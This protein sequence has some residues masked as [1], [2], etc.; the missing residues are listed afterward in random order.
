MLFC[1]PAYPDVLPSAG[2][3]L[4]HRPPS[5]CQN[6]VV[7]LILFWHPRM[8]LDSTSQ[9]QSRLVYRLLSWNR[10]QI[11]IRCAQ[12]WMRAQY[13]VIFPLPVSKMK[14]CAWWWIKEGSIT[15]SAPRPVWESRGLFDDD[16]LMIVMTEVSSW[17]CSAYLFVRERSSTVVSARWATVDW[18]LA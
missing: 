13:L 18:F 6:P 7:Y 5:A 2:N 10:L 15:A 8:V 11:S 1:S 9:L 16:S 12:K 17:I 3:L 4:W 14:W